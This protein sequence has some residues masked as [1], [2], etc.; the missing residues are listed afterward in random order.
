M[1]AQAERNIESCVRPC[2]KDI[3]FLR[4]RRETNEAER[5]DSNIRWPRR[6]KSACASRMRLPGN[7]AVRTPPRRGASSY[8]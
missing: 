3:W 1:H 5:I 8:S 7:T 4:G 2:N 6:P